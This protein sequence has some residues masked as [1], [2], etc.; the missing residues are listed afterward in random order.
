MLTHEDVE[1]TVIDPLLQ[2]IIVLN[3][4]F[5]P[6]SVMYYAGA[7]IFTPT[8]PTP[9]APSVWESVAPAG[10]VI[11]E[12]C[13]GEN[14]MVSKHDGLGGFYTELVLENS[15]LCGFDPNMVYILIDIS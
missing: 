6:T 2:G 12:Y 8:Y 9:V 1:D 11:S 15:P 10:T 14:R 5:K 13:Y 4:Q 3:I 7:E